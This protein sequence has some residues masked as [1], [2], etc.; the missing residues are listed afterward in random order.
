M[1]KRIE[2]SKVL[3]QHFPQKEYELSR[4]ERNYKLN[5]N[6]YQRLTE[7]YEETK[8]TEI[9]EIGN[10]VIAE[11][12][13]VPVAPISPNPTRNMGLA[14]VFGIAMGVGIVLL[15][16]Y[17]DPS[18]KDVEEVK[19]LKIPVTGTIPITGTIPEH[20]EN[21]IENPISSP[22]EAY[23]RLRLNLKF[24]VPYSIDGGIKSMLIS[25][26]RPKEGKS[27]IVSNLGV[28]YARADIETVIIDVDLRK[29]SLHKIFHISPKKG[30]TNFLVGEAKKENILHPTK[31]DK[32]WL[33]PAGHLPPNPTEL[34][35]SEYM[36]TLLSGLRKDFGMVILDSPPLNSCTDGFLLGNLVD[37]VVLI[38]EIGGTPRDLLLQTIS[39]FRS[40]GTNFLGVIINK[41]K[42]K[43]HYRYPYYSYT[44]ESK[45]Q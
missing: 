28:I 33:I 6:V 4:L 21:V 11:K 41:A 23:K 39:S 7:H 44:P 5:E 9:S 34:I 18:I 10:V 27:T 42:E 3:V 13:A 36:K 30:L 31:I 43:L 22:A 29:P 1:E 45:A 14:I 17:L 38:L 40:T 26:C 2:E 16:E 32:L 37:G 20:R 25:S 19:R 8:I 12:A 24:T 35:E 15:L